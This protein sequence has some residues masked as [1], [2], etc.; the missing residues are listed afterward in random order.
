MRFLICVIFQDHG[1]HSHHNGD[2]IPV[3]A[4]RRGRAAGR[5]AARAVHGDPC[6]A[7]RGHRQRCAVFPAHRSDQC[8]EPAGRGDPWPADPVQRV[9]LR[10]PADPAVSGDLGDEPEADAG[11]LG[12]DPCAGCGGGGC[13]HSLGRLCAVRGQCPAAGRLPVGGGHRLDNRSIGSGV[14]FPVDFR[15]AAAEPDHRRRKPAERCRRHR[16]VR[17]V[18]GIR[19]A[20]RP[21]PQ[22]GRGAGTVSGPDLWWCRGGL[23]RGTGRGLADG[24]VCTVR[25]GANLGI[26][27]TALSGLYRCG[28]DDRCIGRDRG[29]DSR[30]DTEPDRTQPPAAAIMD[31]PARCVGAAGALGRGADLCAGRAVHPASAGRGAPQR[32][33]PDRRR[34]RGGHRRARRDP[35]RIAATADTAAG[36]AARG[37][38]LPCGDPVGRV[39]RG[40]DT[41]AGTGRHRKHACPAGSQ[42]PRRHSCHRFHVVH[43]DR[44]GV[45]P[46]LGD[47]A[48]GP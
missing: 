31:Q 33:R 28:T 5:P 36:L 21:R 45:K 14:E 41:G 9:P 6:L 43:A 17:A 46:A 25:T 40:G 20:R 26:R 11:R 4:D 10:V 7:G 29:R 22:S 18:H 3:P 24:A 47:R 39:A 8:A 27:R 44:A 42:A 16:A 15:T 38:A 19:H 13:G 37:P 35:V 48:I 23:V 1:H 30:A 2:R 32:F 12:A 34:H